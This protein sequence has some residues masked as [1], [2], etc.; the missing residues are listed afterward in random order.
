[1]MTAFLLDFCVIGA[2]KAGTTS[3]SQCLAQHPEISFSNPK[4]PHFFSHHADWD[5]RISEYA[6]LFESKP[7][8]RLRGEGSPH[9]ACVP[10]WPESAQRLWAHNPNMK[11]MHILRHPVDRAISAYGQYIAMGELSGNPNLDWYKI[12]HITATGQYHAQIQHYLQYFPID[13]IHFI[14]FDEFV[15]NQTHTL[16]KIADFLGISAEPFATMPPVH[17]NRPEDKLYVRPG[18]AGLVTH[19]ATSRLRMLLP[20]AIRTPLKRLLFREHQTV[21]IEPFS[22]MNRRIIWE[23]TYPDLLLTERITGLDFSDWKARAWHG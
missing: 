22:E 11:L 16:S 12:P 4:E 14:K 10:L 13:Q 20:E 6:R 7:S 5:Q 17:A 19:P 8:A 3:L 15:K 21:S 9:Y 18:M 23:L 1:M 2:G